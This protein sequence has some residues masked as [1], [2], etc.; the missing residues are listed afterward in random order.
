MKNLFYL[1]LCLVLVVSSCSEDENITTPQAPQNTSSD[2]ASIAKRNLQSK[3]QQQ[4]YLNQQLTALNLS[5]AEKEK[6]LKN[7]S[8]DLLD[9]I[10]QAKTLNNLGNQLFAEENYEL[11]LFYYLNSLQVKTAANDL[12]G[13]AISY[14]NAALAYQE[15]GDYENAAINYWQS[16]YIW[17]SLGNK[18]R[19]GQLYNDLGVVYSLS[20]DFLEVGSFS[21]E[22]STSVT[23]YE[24]AIAINETL[25]DFEGIAQAKHNINLLYDNWL[26]EKSGS[27]AKVTGGGD[28]DGDDDFKGSYDQDDVEDEF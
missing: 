11:A 20:H 27:N 7:T 15:K 22:Q 23:F 9:L 8:N 5:Q 6:A 10:F 25:N 14:R 19:Q 13:M 12:E 21:V 28:G 18:S 2:F 16:F 17:E 1:L 4:A 3:D 24:K 26:G